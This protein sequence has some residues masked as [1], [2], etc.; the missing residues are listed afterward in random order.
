MNLHLL[1][2]I[3]IKVYSID[4]EYIITIVRSRLQPVV[5]P[6]LGKGETLASVCVECVRGDSDMRIMKR[7]KKKKKRKIFRRSNDNYKR[8]HLLTNLLCIWIIYY[9][10]YCYSRKLCSFGNNIKRF[11]VLTASWWNCWR[12]KT[13]PATKQH[14]NVHGMAH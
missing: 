5:W 9:F 13:Y 3:I 2:Q 10:S 6:S 11:S 4:H 1:R 14:L 8:M 12:L 7:V